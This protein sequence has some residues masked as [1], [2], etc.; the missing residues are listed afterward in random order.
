MN[1]EDPIWKDRYNSAAETL[2]IDTRIYCLKQNPAIET[3]CMAEVALFDE[4]LKDFLRDHQVIERQIQDFR[5]RI[6]DPY[7]SGLVFAKH[8]LPIVRQQIDSSVSLIALL[9]AKAEQ[10]PD[11][12]DEA[13]KIIQPVEERLV[14]WQGFLDETEKGLGPYKDFVVGLQEEILRVEESRKIVIVG[15]YHPTQDRKNRD[16]V[17][18]GAIL[19]RS[20]S[21][22]L[23]WDVRLLARVHK[24]T[25]YDLGRKKEVY[26]QVRVLCAKD[27]QLQALFDTKNR[28]KMKVTF[29]QPLGETEVFGRTIYEQII[30]NQPIF[31]QQA[32]LEKA[33]E[34][35]FIR[36]TETIFDSS[37]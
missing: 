37:D 11:F 20:S 1:I 5:A 25:V 28:Q 34:D 23:G 19:D 13:D 4:A 24:Q 32:D 30:P 17:Y 27:P 36:R 26:E 10:Y 2:G 31:E 3:F 29:P 14:V 8:N 7:I 6:A 18:R 15:S 33:V 16:G 12:K 21:W 22:L 35:Y 9:R